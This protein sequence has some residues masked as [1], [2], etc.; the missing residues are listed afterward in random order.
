VVDPGGKIRTVVGT[1]Q[2]GASGDGGE[3]LKATLSGPKHLCVDR[4]GAVIIADTDNHI[5]RK[6]TPRDGKIARLAGSGTRG[7]A[8]VGG[9]PEKLELNQP[10]GVYVHSNGDLYIADSGNRRILKV[11]RKVP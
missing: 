6:Y 3:A 7:T 2:K 1:G 11:E 5:I 8:G 9:P 10:H 4:D